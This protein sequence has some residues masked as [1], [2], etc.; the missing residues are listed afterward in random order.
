MKWGYASVSSEKI[1]NMMKSAILHNKSGRV[2]KLFNEY[3]NRF[4]KD[5]KF[6]ITSMLYFAVLSRK[7][8]MVKTLLDLGVDPNAPNFYGNVLNMAAGGSSKIDIVKMLLEHGADPNGNE[9]VNPL[10]SAAAVDKGKTVKLLIEAGADQNIPTKLGRHFITPLMKAIDN[11]YNKTVKI[12][13]GDPKLAV[14]QEQAA[15]IMERI[16]N[17][18]KIY[19]G[20]LKDETVE[21]LLRN[22]VIHKEALRILRDPSIECTKKLRK[23]SDSNAFS[24]GD[25]YHFPCANSNSKRLTELQTVDTM[26]RSLLKYYKPNYRL[27]RRSMQEYL[28]ADKSDC[29][30]MPLDDL[31]LE[32]KRIIH[33][34][35]DDERLMRKVAKHIAKTLNDSMFQYK[36]APV[37]R[38][39]DYIDYSIRRKLTE[40]DLCDLIN[41]LKK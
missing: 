39:M 35:S 1:K 18:E 40:R 28:S 2:R 41:R 26:N 31:I 20:R 9:H 13:I 22:P 10:F 4:D 12:L 36:T 3:Q 11:G 16:W 14:T 37:Y 23:L 38:I 25:R 29:E 6:N 15:W 34:N 30:N 19:Y 21:L 17:P 7:P 24:R 8:E 27:S 32:A 33:G 5:S